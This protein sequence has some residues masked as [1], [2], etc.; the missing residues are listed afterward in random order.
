MIDIS[1]GLASEIGH[2]CR[3]SGLG[4]VVSAGLIPVHRDVSG[5]SEERG[6]PAIEAALHSGEE[7]ELLFTLEKG[8]MGRVR[9][10]LAPLDLEMTVIGEMAPYESGLTLESSD[11]TRHPLDTQGWDHFRS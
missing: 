6:V 11:G 7:Y 3:E 10:G 5:W 1:D 4:C 8:M 2:L 9:K